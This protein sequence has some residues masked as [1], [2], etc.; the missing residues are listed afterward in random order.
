MD[1]LIYV[2]LGLTSIVGVAFVIER[3]W[4]LRWKKVVPPDITR[5]LENCRTSNEIPSLRAACERRPS[6]LGRLL[7]LATDRLDWPKA[8]NVDRLQTAARHEIVR[9]ERGLV[10]LEIIVG[11][12]PLLGLVG[13]II[14]MIDVFGDL[15][16]TGLN[17][18]AK[19]ASGISVIL[20]A[21]L[22]G[23]LIAIP[24]LIAWSYFSKKVEVLA[25]EME[26]LCDDFIRRQYAGKE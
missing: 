5:A 12:A 26:A 4:M 2:L 22:I 15:G 14:G 19:L 23:L 11:I 16:K 9:L 1:L 3:A 17:E 20:Q 8:D 24:A 13:T 6:P 10:V 7:L 18:A 21:T 25:V